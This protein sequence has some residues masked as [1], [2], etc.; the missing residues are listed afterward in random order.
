MWRQIVWNEI[1]TIIGL[2]LWYNKK[3]DVEVGGIGMKVY[4][5]PTCGTYK[6]AVKW[7]QEKNINIETFNLKET[8]PTKDELANYHLLSGL[9]LKK[10]FNTSGKVYRELDLKNRQKEMTN[11]EIYQLLSDNPMLIKRPL[12]VDG[13]FVTVGFK[14]EVYIAKW[15]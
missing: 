12:I 8:S 4:G 15:L 11:E 5:I 13:D 10:F 1:K 14:E 6:K 7:F 9:E 2:F 3:V